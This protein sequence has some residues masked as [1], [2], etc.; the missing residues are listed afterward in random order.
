MGAAH[1]AR[2]KSVQLSE[3]RHNGRRVRLQ[4]LAFKINPLTSGISAGSAIYREHQMTAE[5]QSKKFERSERTTR[6][7]F[8]MSSEAAVQA[9][10]QAERSYSSA[11][12]GIR[13]LNVRLLD[14]GQT[15][16]M[17]ALEFVRE[18]TTAKGPKEA[19][20]VWSKHTNDQ[21]QRFTANLRN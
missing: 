12:E 15:N 2:G 16:G 19:F 3:E 10:R 6:E 11:A 4:E 1:L 13:E 21:F 18:L 7:G 17:A 14:M 20:E 8:D 9:T 5:N